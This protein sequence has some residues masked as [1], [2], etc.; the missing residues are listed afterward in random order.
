MEGKQLSTF[1][2]ALVSLLVTT[3]VIGVRCVVRKSIGG[4]GLDDW[5]MVVGQ[6]CVLY[7]NTIHV[8]NNLRCIGSVLWHMRLRHVRMQHRHWYQR[9][10]L[11]RGAACQRKTFHCHV[12]MLLPHLSHLRQGKHLLCSAPHRHSQGNTPIPLLHHLPL[13]LLWLRHHDGLLDPLRPSFCFM[14]WH[15]QMR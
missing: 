9:H 2:V 15:W 14:D 4:F 3:V 6:V 8:H 7:L 12:P 10:P 5:S 13:L 1:V 11:D